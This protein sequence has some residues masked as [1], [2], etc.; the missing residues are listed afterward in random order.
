MLNHGVRPHIFQKRFNHTSRTLEFVAFASVHAGDQI[1]LHCTAPTHPPAHTCPRR[2]ITH[3]RTHAYTHARAHAR[4]HARTHAHDG[5]AKGNGSAGPM[6]RGLGTAAQGTAAAGAKAA[7]LSRTRADGPLTN[8][9]L[10]LYYGFALVCRPLATCNIQHASFN[11]Q[12]AA[13]NMQHATYN[14]HQ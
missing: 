6:G 1:F 2:S 7:G 8:A 4:T 10:M 9:E 5:A 11:I 3:T 13:C 14:I 12:H